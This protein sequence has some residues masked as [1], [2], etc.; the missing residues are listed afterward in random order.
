MSVIDGEERLYFTNGV[1]Q[2]RY[3]DGNTIYTV[4]DGATAIYGKFLACVE[5]VLVLAN[6]GTPHSNNELVFAKAGTHQFR[7]DQD[8]T[9]AD[10][11]NK[12]ILDAEI[13]GLA[14]LGWLVYVFTAG[15][16]LWE[17][18]LRTGIPRMISTVGCLAPRSI[19]VGSGLMVWADQFSFWA[20]PLNGSV[21][22]IGEDIEQI[23]K[24][25]QATNIYKLNA[26]ITQDGQYKCWIGQCSYEGVTYDNVELVYDIEQ[27]ILLKDRIWKIRKD[28]PS[29]AKAKWTNSIGFT[30]TYFASNTQILVYQDNI[31]NTYDGQD[32]DMVWQSKD[33]PLADEKGM[34]TLTEFYF[35]YK[36][37]ATTIP[38]T[39]HMRSDMG[40]WQLVKSVTLPADTT[41]D[42]AMG[43]IEFNRAMRGRTLAIKISVD[44]ANA[45]RLYECKLYYAKNQDNLRAL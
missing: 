23:Y 16:G 22:R 1:D 41:K 33:I 24:T 6:L 32:I 45:F 21:T 25:I 12:V 13:T 4:S 26:T 35:K 20:L 8:L 2:L 11:S 3:T 44:S 40:E 37:E 36:P 42:M 15:D 19:A 5:N 17:L 14:S 27:S 30:N 10:T 18:D 29:I 38:F 43:K 9:F 34:A 7:R 39:L 28:K 31:G